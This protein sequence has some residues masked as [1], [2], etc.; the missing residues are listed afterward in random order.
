MARYAAFLR[1]VNLAG[2]R[3]TP[4]AALRAAFAEMGF[5]DV[6]TFRA[7]GNVVFSAAGRGG[8]AKLTSV[9]ETGLADAF[10]FEIQVFLRTAA[11]LRAIA[12]HEPFDP[13]D[14][15]RSNGKLQ[16][17]LLMKNPAAAARRKV[18]ALATDN[19]R[20]AIK[21][22]ELYWLPAGGT[23]ESSLDRNAIDR[24]VGPTTRRTMGTI[25][26]MVAKHLD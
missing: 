22:R 17:D 7:S 8:E 10:G 23:M 19:D 2:N 9:A 12:A 20:L 15:K 21:G 14:V 24:L 25:A 26:A 5:E 16:I 1:A 13:A 18:L 11:E 3:K 6:A 4:G